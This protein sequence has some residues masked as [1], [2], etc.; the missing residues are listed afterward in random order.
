[1]PTPLPEN[2]VLYFLYINL[3]QEKIVMATQIIVSQ[4]G[5][6]PISVNF[7]SPSD[8]PSTLMVFGSVWTQGTN[9]MIGIQVTLDGQS[10]GAA[11]I[12]ANPAATHMNVVPAVF[13]IKLQQGN[14][15]LQLSVGTTSTVSDYNDFYTVVLQY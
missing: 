13:P 4:K 7:P 3:K 10:L 15:T 12:F 8:G 1:M 11:Q 6:L 5:P 14:H 9:T 2:G